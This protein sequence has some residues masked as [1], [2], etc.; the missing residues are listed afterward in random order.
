MHIFI[1]ISLILF[2]CAL[3]CIILILFSLTNNS[4]ENNSNYEAYNSEKQI[5]REFNNGDNEYFKRKRAATA[6]KRKLWDEGV[7]PFEIG[8]EYLYFQ[9]KLIH[10]AFREWEAETCLKFIP[11]E[12]SH[13]YRIIVKKGGSCGCCSLFGKTQRKQNLIINYVCNYSMILHELGHVIGFHHEQNRPD[14]DKYIK[15]LYG[16]IQSSK[17]VQYEKLTKEEVNSLGFPYDYNSIMH[18]SSRYFSVS[19]KEETMISLNQSVS[20][21]EERKHLSK[22]DIAQT[23]KLYNCPKCLFNIRDESR[24]IST[25]DQRLKLAKERYC[26]WYIKRYP[27][28][29]IHFYIDYH[30]ITETENCSENYLEIR[31]GYWSKSPLIGR[32]CGKQT[33]RNSNFILYKSLSNYLLI[34][35]KR[36]SSYSEDQG[37]SLT[38]KTVCD[39]IIEADEGIIQSPN[40]LGNYYFH[41][42]CKW[43]ITVSSGYNVALKFQRF[44]IT[45]E[46]CQSNFLEIVDGSC[47][48]NNLIGRYSGNEMPK[49]IIST[50]NTILM[51][52][53]SDFS[54]SDYVQPD[55]FIV[56]FV[57]EIDECEYSE[58]NGCSDICVNTIGSYRC[59]CREG[60]YAFTNDKICES[61]SNA[62][63]G[64]LN[65]TEKTIITSPL[66]PDNYPS[67]STCIW[68]VINQNVMIKFLRLQ[69]EGKEPSCFDKLIITSGDY[70]YEYCSTKPEA[71]NF[72][73]IDNLKIEFLSDEY[74]NFSGFAILIE[75]F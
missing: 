42:E 36:T 25:K 35:Y 51:K 1:I 19:S 14:R 60:R 48:E 3:I 67:Y 74:E 17:R 8:Y 75:P 22:I 26:Q 54:A 15:I 49:D 31:D 40:Y 34:T 58:R 18:Y 73:Q 68:E 70:D 7:I 71:L 65:I 64:I 28:E 52:Y 57:K 55:G 32:F 37:F 59:E 46:N 62:C 24:T 69:L 47:P 9:F 45:E 5:I 30:D 50:N 23:N 43:I 4:L 72:T 6:I 33:Y 61:Y 53:K 12:P 27:G 29:F 20:L 41:V 63:G 21:E 2:L 39:R 38:Y 66:F 44:Q 10:E 13:E 11:A 16:N 56:N